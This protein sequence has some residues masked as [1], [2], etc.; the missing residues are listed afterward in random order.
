MSAKR[1][2]RLLLF[3]VAKTPDEQLP[4]L[5]KISTNVSA[6]RSLVAKVDAI[7]ADV[8]RGLVTYSEVV[9]RLTKLKEILEPKQRTSNTAIDNQIKEIKDITAKV[10]SFHVFLEAERDRFQQYLKELGVVLEFK[11]TNDIF[12]SAERAGVTLPTTPAA[13]TSTT[14]KTTPTVSLDDIGF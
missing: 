6:C 7:A 10:E 9:E 2:G 8:E 13:D 12:S 5:K 3:A 14:T 4:T 11:L 1:H